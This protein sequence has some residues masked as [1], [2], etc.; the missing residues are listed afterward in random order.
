MGRYDNL[1]HRLVCLLSSHWEPESDSVI[2]WVHA[3]IQGWLPVP[4][5]M[6]AVDVEVG[7]DM[8]KE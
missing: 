1:S 8:A 2:A 5:R 4:D 3:F 7:D 6:P